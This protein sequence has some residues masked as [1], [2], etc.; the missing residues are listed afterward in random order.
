MIVRLAEIEVDPVHLGEYKAILAEEIEAA[1][2]LEPGVLALEAVALKDSATSI[3]ILEVYADSLAYE[4][5]LKTAH[6][7][8]YKSLS[9]GMVRS[10]RL[11]ETEP[12]ILRSKA[13]A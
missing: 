10:L 6:F 8:K 4:A 5:H 7:L 3:R 12:V 9:E 1:I 11:V 13:L 2:A